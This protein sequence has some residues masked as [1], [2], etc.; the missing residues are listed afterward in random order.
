MNEQDPGLEPEAVDPVEEAFGRRHRRRRHR[1]KIP[2]ESIS[3]LNLT[4]MMD[5]MT[6]LLVFLV[7]SYEAAPENITVT[8]S[9]KPPVS[10]VKVAVAPA[11][12]L[13]VTK[14]EIL[15]EDHPV[16]ALTDVGGGEQVTIPALRDALVE[17][18][19]HLRAVERRGGAPFDGRLMVVADQTTPYAVLTAVLL[20][21]GEAKYAEYKL[22]VMQKSEE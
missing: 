3:H 2:G 20:T 17:R 15:V 11:T 9:L 22:V 8:D 7:K 4:P 16:M 21:A 1:R 13:T 10:T 12:K 18:A 14:D 5:I 6:I 19:D